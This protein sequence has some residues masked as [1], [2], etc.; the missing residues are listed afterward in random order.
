MQTYRKNRKIA[1]YVGIPYAKAPIGDLRFHAPEA[2][3]NWTGELKLG[4]AGTEPL[5][6]QLISGEVVG[7]EDCLKLSVYT[8]ENSSNLPIFV[9][10]HGGS[11]MRGGAKEFGPQLLLDRDIILVTVN[12]RLG[13]LGFLSTEDEAIS[14]NWG[15]K[16]QLR[17]IQWIKENA[18]AFG[19]NPEKI[20]VGGV[21]SGGVS[22]HLHAMSVLSR[23]LL[24]AVISMSGTALRPDVPMAKGVA[25]RRA[26]RI[27]ERLGCVSSNLTSVE[28]KGCLRS[29]N[30]EEILKADNEEGWGPVVEDY[31][32]DIEVAFLEEPPVT[33]LTNAMTHDLPWLTGFVKTDGRDRAPGKK[34]G[35]ATFMTL[36][37]KRLPTHGR[38]GQKENPL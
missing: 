9:W 16:D 15:L 37:S 27:A 2:P 4:Q 36:M 24:Y 5:C 8:P 26:L 12:Y 17:A 35:E 32:D 18:Q 1:A 22:A 6:P 38:S 25:R 23:R 20:T 34:N 7:E 14:G 29:A 11:F 28:A 31:V 30:V 33:T 21:G 10:L 13:A 19:G 3:K